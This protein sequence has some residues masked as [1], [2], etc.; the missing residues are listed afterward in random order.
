M[1]Q[2][3][4]DAEFL[5]KL[6]PTEKSIGGPYVLYNGSFSIEFFKPDP[7][8]NASVLLKAIYKYDHPLCKNGKG[9][10]QSPPLHIHFT[11]SETFV[12]LSGKIGTTSSPTPGQISKVRDQIHVPGEK[13]H[14]MVP[15]TPHTFWPVADAEEDSTMIMW[16]TPDGKYPPMMDAAFFTTILLY[17][18]DVNDKK[19]PMD[20]GQVLLTQTESDSVGVMFPGA[21]W[22]GSLRWRVPWAMQIAFGS[23]AQ[24]QGK[25]GMIERY[26]SEEDWKAYLESKKAVSKKST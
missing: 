17:L 14:E 19:V 4:T 6:Q 23:I 5:S 16:A 9:H 20:I 15:W 3:R 22:L 8:R 11:Q 12:V 18:S 24:W 25:H 13:P 2:H 26:V 10:P 1:V 7:R 21:W